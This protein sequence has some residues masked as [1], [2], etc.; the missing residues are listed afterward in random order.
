MSRWRVTFG[1]FVLR[2]HPAAIVFFQAFGVDIA[3][4]AMHVRH[5]AHA[6]GQPHRR[7]ADAAVNLHVVIAFGISAEICMSRL[8]SAHM[9]LDAAQVQGAQIHLGVPRAQMRQDIQRNF[10]VQAELPFAQRPEPPK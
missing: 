1:I 8:P 4:A 5:D 9:H 10:V 2:T 7:V 6:R 3:D